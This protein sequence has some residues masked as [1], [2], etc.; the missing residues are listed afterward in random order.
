M[1]SRFSSDI[2]CISRYMACRW[3]SKS[4]QPYASTLGIW[5]SSNKGASNTTSVFGIATG[6]FGI[7][8][9][10]SGNATGGYGNTTGKVITI[11][12]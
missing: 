5:H 8:T 10:S 11:K 6:I 9:G 4:I 2:M 12:I 3:I 7:A 1:A